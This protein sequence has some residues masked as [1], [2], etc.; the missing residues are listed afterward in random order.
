LHG[1]GNC[2]AC[3]P[4]TLLFTFIKLVS[5]IDLLVIGQPDVSDLRM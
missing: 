1:A 3:V 2:D 4:V 5:D